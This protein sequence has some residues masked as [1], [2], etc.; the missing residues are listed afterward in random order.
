M[1]PKNKKQKHIFELSQNLQELTEKQKKWGID[2]C[3]DYFARATHKQVYCLNCGEITD[4]VLKENEYWTCPVCGKKV[5]IK[6]TLKRHFI[7]REYYC[8]IDICEDF[9]V[10]RFFYI[11]A[12]FRVGKKAKFFIKE[13]IQRW[14]DC[15]GN[16]VTIALLRN[17][18]WYID[19]WIFGSSFEIRTENSVYNI[20]PTKIYPK[21]KIIDNIKR[22]GFNN[23]FYGINP[24]KIFIKLLTNHYAE[25]LLKSGQV[26]ILKSVI[27]EQVDI[28]KYWNSIKICIRNKYIVKDASIWFDLIDSLIYLNKD[29]LNRNN[30][31]PDDLKSFHDFYLKQKVKQREKSKMIEKRKQK[32]KDVQKFNQL[33]K[34]FFNMTFS[35]GNIEIKSLNS[36][37]D[38]FDEGKALHHCVFE[39]EYYLKETTL[40]LSAQKNNKRIATIELQLENLEII[41]CR[42]NLNKQSNY[43][44]EIKALIHQ[45]Q[46]IIK[47]KI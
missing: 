39:N 21:M 29:V 13:V 20:N 2:K 22:N 12:D 25:T 23:K 5:K 7:Q 41:Q 46:Q 10:L 17:R 31:C 4:E 38:Y 19:N 14:I 27:Y 37:D 35:N 40:I 36:I 1:K 42:G 18:N 32:L 34:K 44:E 43:Y 28:K 6:H 33:K 26:N 15:Q 9:Q 11:E 24:S 47:E 30:V 16:I 3:I 8:V 45:N